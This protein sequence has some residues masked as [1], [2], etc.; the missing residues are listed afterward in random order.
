MS[1]GY[2][3]NPYQQGG[4]GGYGQQPQGY[5]QQP[6]GY[7]QP[8]AYP[9]GYGPQQGYGQP[10]AYGQ[11]F[12]YGAPPVPQGIPG[13]VIAGFILSLFICPLVGVI[14]CGV[15]LGEA[16]RR[17]AGVGLAY[18]GIIIGLIWIVLGIVINVAG[19]AVR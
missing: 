7:G 18:A 3:Q 4:Q 2:N 10:Q 11:P 12:G 1:G 17:N 19:A 16:K 14:L 15:G 8:G 9:P 13:T 6:A 5:G